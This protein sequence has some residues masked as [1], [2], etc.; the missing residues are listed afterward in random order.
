MKEEIL[1]IL[2]KL[3][4]I[5]SRS[6]GGKEEETKVVEQFLIDQ[7]NEHTA[8][9]YYLRFVRYLQ[10]GVEE[11]IQELCARA[12]KELTRAQKL[13]VMTRLIELVLADGVISPN[14][15]QLIEEI[16]F[17][18]HLPV[19]YVADIINFIN[20]P[21]P[22]PV[23]GEINYIVP[24]RT[25]EMPNAIV[26]P[27]IR[28]RIKVLH[29][30]GSNAFLLLY[31]KGQDRIQ[32]NGRLLLPKQIQVIGPGSI[33]HFKRGQV[34]YYSDIYNS[35]YKHQRDIIPI[36]FVAQEIS[37]RF[38]NGQIGLHPF[39]FSASSGE[40]IAIMGA[41][42]AGKST[43]LSLLNGLKKPTSGK[44]L[45][46]GIDIHKQPEKVKSLIGY[47][48]QDDL[49]IEE[50]TVFENLY[51]N[52]K[53]C[54]GKKSDKEIRK[55]VNN[56]L[57]DL[58]LYEIRN[59]RVGSPLNKLISGGQRKRLNIALEL[60][61]EPHV[62][63]LDEPTSGLSS[64][65]SEI[66]IDLLKQLSRRG[67]L[68]FVV[69]HQPSSD[70][71]TQFDK[72]L[73]LDK[74]GY[75]A[76]YG[77]P[78]EAIAYFRKEAEI[79]DYRNVA[80]GECGNVDP[81]ELFEILE[82]QVI[83][84]D[85][86]P[87]G[88]RKFTPQFWY[89]KFLERG[90]TTSPPPSPPPLPSQ[91]YRVANPL[92][93]FW[94]F[95]I[96]DL[97]AKWNNFSYLFLTLSE[98]PLL[99]LF[100]TVLLKFHPFNE[101]YTLYKNLNFPVY[102]FISVIVALFLGMILS[103]EEIIKD[104]KIRKREHFLNLSYNSYLLGKCTVLMIFSAIQIASFIWIGHSIMELKEF[105][106]EHFCILFATALFAVI[107]GLNVSATFDSA[108]TAYISIPILL[109]PQIILSGVMVDYRQLNPSFSNQKYV[110]FV[111]DILTARWA[112]EAL[113]VT[114]FKENQ[115]ERHFYQLHK[116]QSEAAY[117][118]HHWIPT[119]ATQ[120]QLYLTDADTNVIHLIANEVS[121]LTYRFSDID[122]SLLRKPDLNDKKA[123]LLYV[124]NASRLLSKLKTFFQYRFQATQK[125]LDERI[126]QFPSDSL[127]TLK[128][129]YHNE[130]LE[131]LVRNKNLPIQ[132]LRLHN[133]LIPIIDPIFMT[134]L[135]SGSFFDYRTPLY[136]PE[137]PILGYYFPTYQFNL[138]VIGLLIFLFYITLA[139]DIFRRTGNG[140]V[141]LW[142]QLR[143]IV[144]KKQEQENPIA[145]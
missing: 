117:Y 112:Y 131:K 24:K 63:F 13:F 9:I 132:I 111:G 19:S 126:R 50:L 35:F 16:A 121:K 37:Y 6:E 58:G 101:E 27:N 62:L 104:R 144:W 25:P 135:S 87:T 114:T 56:V 97:K 59:L 115:Y 44:V 18:L 11:T 22:T 84:E 61:R 77:N 127:E 130:Q 96:R 79:I 100:L 110:P 53:L 28:T 73:L 54:F 92:K 142:F 42:G 34:L 122:T 105:H 89:K 72:L 106:L 60:I 119:M 17:E 93:Q 99:A 141:L 81:D 20:D 8:S 103:A 95:F 26:I 2:L 52:A 82:A 71:Y 47:V 21:F 3:F 12:N 140:F 32:I 74:G 7:F 91:E 98:A 65:D 38:P 46:N 139:L 23:K 118:L 67:K 102:L 113:A 107:L 15:R 66:V 29:F 143:R 69:I 124:S 43:L 70:I 1:D 57:K 88:E 138:S 64:Q 4:A 137:K 145:L 85:G 94:I 45:L 30:P 40:M 33:I 78:L 136:V 51:Y 83:N 76:F 123:C 134:P 75:P 55:I 109:I 120:I 36:L 80:C 48:P 5:I 31:D 49:L 116:Q 129:L 39:S 125:D 128:Q 41:S 108:V 14:E 10:K 68:I 86:M 133:E 90:K